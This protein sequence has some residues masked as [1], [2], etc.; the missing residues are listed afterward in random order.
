MSNLFF[1]LFK[2]SPF[3]PLHEHM[4]KVRE[5][6]ALLR[7]LFE[8]VLVDKDPTK[9]DEIVKNISKTE[10]QADEIKNEI[11][12]TLPGNLFLPVNR[13]D[14]LGYLKTQD[15]IADSIEDVSVLMTLKTFEVPDELAAEIFK[16][17][18][19]VLNVFDFCDEAEAEFETLVT[20]AFGE[21]ERHRL[22]SLVQ[23]AE[24]AEWEADKAQMA[25]AKK[26]FSFEDEMKA[27][28]IFLLFRVF[29][30]LGGVANHAEKTGDR[31]RRLLI[32]S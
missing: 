17:V 11:R 26:L 9:I 30:E 6:V 28:D 16:F 4:V 19:K 24:H 27:T 7:P 22:L 25:A 32:K 12:Q 23:K 21:A 1:D 10:H 5:C 13:E 15:D 18:D 3:G 2:K 31:L 20:S 14:L 29:G 8:A